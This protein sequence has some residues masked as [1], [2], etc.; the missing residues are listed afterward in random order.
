[1]SCLYG[2]ITRRLLHESAGKPLMMEV[3]SY[4]ER[5]MKRRSQHSSFCSSP[6]R[7]VLEVEPMRE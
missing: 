5:V 6:V 4:R 3:P 2:E 7:R 1:M